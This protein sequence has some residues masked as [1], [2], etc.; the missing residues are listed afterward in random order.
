MLRRKLAALA[1][2][3]LSTASAEEPAGL[4]GLWRL[5]ERK[6][7]VRFI[8]RGGGFDGVIESSQ[9]SSEVGFVLFR[10]V[11]PG[12]GRE[13]EGTLAMPENGSTHAVVLTVDGDRLRA[14]VGKGLFS[15]TLLLERAR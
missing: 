10:R 5:D 9:R 1:V 7:Q 15:K 3:S 8:A 4:P 14:V 12:A 13:L 11:K 6:S 2:L